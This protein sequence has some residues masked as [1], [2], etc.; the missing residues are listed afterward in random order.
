MDISL[1]LDCRKTIQAEIPGVRLHRQV[2]EL[3]EHDI[4]LA[5][6]AERL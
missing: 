4:L 3:Q 1:G 5:E 6:I 2:C